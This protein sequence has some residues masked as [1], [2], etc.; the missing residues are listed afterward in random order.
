MRRNT[1]RTHRSEPRLLLMPLCQLFTLCL[2]SLPA[3]PS[4]LGARVTK[5]TFGPAVICS[6]L[7]V[8]SLLSPS[9]S[10]LFALLSLVLRLPS[11]F[12]FLSNLVIIYSTTMR[13]PLNVKRGIFFAP[14]ATTSSGD[15][16]ELRVGNMG[17]K[18]VVVRWSMASEMTKLG[19][20]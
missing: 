5:P 18:E 13:R 4:V 17:S 11:F 20:A 14:A 1:Q 19:S 8:L 3:P 12:L 16:N 7:F 2:L 9:F 6:S 10:L 15:P